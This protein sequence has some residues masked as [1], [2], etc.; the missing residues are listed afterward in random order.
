ML[1]AFA[2]VGQRLYVSLEAMLPVLKSQQAQPL[3]RTTEDASDADLAALATL[4]FDNGDALSL[5]DSDSDGDLAAE[6]E[7][8]RSR[9]RW[10]ASST[11]R[12][13]GG[14]P[15]SSASPACVGVGRD[16]ESLNSLRSH[17]GLFQTHSPTA[18]NVDP[19]LLNK[20]ICA[21]QQALR[22]GARGI[23]LAQLGP[24]AHYTVANLIGFCGPLLMDAL[25]LS[26]DAHH[27]AL[28]DAFVWDRVRMKV[29]R[30]TSAFLRAQD[31]VGL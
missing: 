20:T 19:A 24:D 6:L 28:A 8:L 17:T 12:K 14:A 3:V 16:R 29:R 5:S 26:S 18:P 13:S 9:S 4:T 30:L 27:R 21:L 1:G 23:L 2:A 15:A 11:P 22:Q 25:R 31:D 10:A 7:R